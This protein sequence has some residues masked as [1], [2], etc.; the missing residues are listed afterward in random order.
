[1]QKFVCESLATAML[2]T[3]EW[4]C[5][6]SKFI[7]AKMKVSD[8]ENLFTIDA[9]LLTKLN[10]NHNSL[11]TRGQPHSEENEFTDLASSLKHFFPLHDDY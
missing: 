6:N 10:V 7:V 4:K 3:L 2:G 1:M 8:Q 5:Y 9:A 11:K